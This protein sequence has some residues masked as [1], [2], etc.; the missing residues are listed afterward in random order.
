MEYENGILK[1]YLNNTNKNEGSL[2]FF[3]EDI[4][5]LL[6]KPSVSDN[7]N[8]TKNSIY[9]RGAAFERKIQIIAVSSL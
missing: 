3:N 9:S 8:D 4:G 1:S 5:E 2:E 6:A 7:P